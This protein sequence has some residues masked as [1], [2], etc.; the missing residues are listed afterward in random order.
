MARLRDTDVAR[1][2]EED[3]GV[4]EREAPVVD[5][6]ASR[7]LAGKADRLVE[8]AVSHTMRHP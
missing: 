3:E 4:L 8:V 2:R 5:E 7:L 6:Q 1:Y